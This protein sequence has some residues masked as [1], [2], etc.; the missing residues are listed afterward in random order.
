M[1][2]KELRDA[3]DEYC[4]DVEVMMP[5]GTGGNM[6]VTDIDSDQEEE[7]ITLC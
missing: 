6:P 3:L 1:T 2:A 7:Y 5:C 4:D